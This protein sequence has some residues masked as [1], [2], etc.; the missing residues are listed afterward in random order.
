MKHFLLDVVGVFYPNF[1]VLCT[2]SALLLSAIFSLLFSRFFLLALVF[3]LNRIEFSVP[4]TDP[5]YN[6][7][8]CCMMLNE[9]MKCAESCFYS[10]SNS[11]VLVPS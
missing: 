11:F 1:N 3:Y 10:F 7:S 6:R 2:Y 8:F 4:S 5:P 9:S